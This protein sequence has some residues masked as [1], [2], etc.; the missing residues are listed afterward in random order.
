MTEAMRVL[1]PGLQTTVQDLGRCGFSHLG[2]SASGPADSISARIGNRL[3]GNHDNCAVL[4]MTLL[5]GTFEFVRDCTIALAGADL[6]T[7]LDGIPVPLYETVDVGSGATLR[8]GSAVKG[9]R[10]Y[11][12]I[13]GGFE[14]RA[15][16]GSASTHV[17][18]GIGGIE[19][20]ALIRGDILRVKADL[21]AM[22]RKVDRS[23]IEQFVGRKVLR[24]TPGPQQAI[25]G[26]DGLRKLCSQTYVVSQDS[27]RVGVRLHGEAIEAVHH[28]EM[29]TEGAALGAI[30]VPSEGNPIILFVE[31]QTTGGYPKIANV[32]SADVP[33]VGQL[34]AQD[35]IRFE[36]ITIQRAIEILRHQEEILN[37]VI[38]PA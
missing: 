5:G 19:G 33:S 37:Q 25:F 20:R 34:R 30:Q 13:G 24:V 12:A 36:L 26:E 22:A 2:V 11:L 23:L 16:L 21:P 1:S 9:A 35:E 7:T 32:I 38:P 8:C 31:H 14:I 4:E 3:V 29:L 18:S 6:A 15:V 28:A 10:C 17:T 27:N